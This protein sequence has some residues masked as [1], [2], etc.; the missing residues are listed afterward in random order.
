MGLGTRVVEARA[1]TLPGST[2]GLVRGK[3]SHHSDTE[4][5]VQTEF[6]RVYWGPEADV[7]PASA[8]HESQSGE[9]SP[10]PSGE[11]SLASRASLGS[12]WTFGA[13]RPEK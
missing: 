2:S 6:F 10:P 3:V 5:T 8:E 13:L 4:T 11:G 9:P 12:G 1:T 7:V